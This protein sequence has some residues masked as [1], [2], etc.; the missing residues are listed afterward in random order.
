M[1]EWI[2][3]ILLSIFFEITEFNI[4]KQKKLFILGI[5]IT[6]L[7]LPV[8]AQKV[9]LNFTNVRF[10]NVLTSIK[11]QTGYDLIY[12]DQVVDVNKMVTISVHKVEL[13]NA[14]SQLLS[15]TDISYR[16]E[17]KKIYLLRR[18][19]N[20]SKGIQKNASRMIKGKVVDEKG[21]PVI[22]ASVLV[23]LSL[24]HI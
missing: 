23:K 19:N 3:Q 18:Q 9:S 16:I 4:M 8:W 10:D 5:L 12:S 11:Q 22:G 15:N 24:I 6:C 21:E 13:A 20:A 14:L 17:G 2:K 1:N 7:S